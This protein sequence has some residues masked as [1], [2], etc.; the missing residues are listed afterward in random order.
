[1]MI[2]I[3]FIWNACILLAL[4]IYSTLQY[5]RNEQ[6]W[7]KQ[8]N[9]LSQRAPVDFSSASFTEEQH[10]WFV[11]FYKKLCVLGLQHENGHSESQVYSLE[12]ESKYALVRRNCAYNFPVSDM[13]WYSCTQTCI[14]TTQ[15]PYTTHMA[16]REWGRLKMRILFYHGKLCILI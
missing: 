8:K 5:W 16:S 10:L 2:D 1:M 9:T 15:T 14:V 13:N 3:N 7:G 6:I 11:E 12:L 4:F